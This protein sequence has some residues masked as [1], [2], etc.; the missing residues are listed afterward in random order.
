MLFQKPSVRWMVVGLGNPGLA[1][2]RS[3]HNIGF[4]TI[5][6]LCRQ[7][8]CRAERLRAKAL[9]GICEFAGERV[10]LVKPVT[11]MNLSGLAVR[12]LADDYK[13][14]AER[15]LVIFDD[16]S[17]PVGKLRVRPSGSAGGHNGVKSLIAALDSQSFPRIKIGVGAKPHPDYDL[18]DWVLSDF[19]AQEETLL[20]SALARALEAAEA[21]ISCGVPEAMNRFNGNGN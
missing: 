14:P 17:L 19:T 1:Y 8:G 13:I 11:Y 9:T 6:L 16:I 21:V 18:A 5:D 2:E 10:L 20:L 4:R 3:R 12:A 7:K 15:I